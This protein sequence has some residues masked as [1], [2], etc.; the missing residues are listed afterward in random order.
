MVGPSCEA[1]IDCLTLFPNS[2]A[3]HFYF[4]LV[5]LFTA[6]SDATMR[7]TE[8]SKIP[9]IVASLTAKRQSQLQLRRTALCAPFL[10]HSQR[11]IPTPLRDACRGFATKS[12]PDHTLLSPTHL[13][14]RYG[15]ELPEDE[16][17]EPR[18]G[19]HR[20]KIGPMV[21]ASCIFGFTL[22]L[23]GSYYYGTYSKAVRVAAR[24]DLSQNSD[25]S[26]RWK[27]RTRDFD[28]EVDVSEKFLLL[29]AKRRRLVNQAFG[30][31][32][33][34]SC[35]TGRNMEL[36]DLRPY[37]PRESEGYGRSRKTIITSIT[38]N[39][40]SEVMVEHAENKFAEMEAKR[41]HMRRFNG[42]VHF[43]VGD[44]GIKGVIP[45]PEG[46]YDTI[47]QTMGVCSMVDAPG[48]LR[49]LGE[50]CR[51]PGERSKLLAS[52]ADDGKG[53]KILLLEHGRSYWS[54]INTLLDNGAK[55]HANHYG[56]W[57]NKDVAET[58]KQ[59]G[60]VV[61]RVRRYNFGTTYEYT[62]RPAKN[63]I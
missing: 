38:F 15:D 8:G 24:L 29:K 2:E 57:W 22:A 58:V 35:G 18:A 32:L 30:S 63:G 14:R 53:G 17:D 56:C 54:W 40:Q 6:R 43:V 33:E 9:H 51:Q 12:S 23:Y 37:D 48:F 4:S 34:V 11:R 52:E 47:V 61:E 39:D 21:W 62:L 16:D 46:G 41:P 25:V 27:D 19:K 28:D 50:L 31:V 60:L 5:E 10:R 3:I 59:S 55:M 49:R 45:R 36:Y 20:R 1:E 26:D 7:P 13:R 42:Y 44:A